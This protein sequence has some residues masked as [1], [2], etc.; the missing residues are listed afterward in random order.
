MRRRRD[1]GC[2]LRRGAAR[3]AIGTGCATG[4]ERRN[5]WRAQCGLETRERFQRGRSGAAQELALQA[6]KSDS[7]HLLYEQLRLKARLFESLAS[8][9]R[10]IN[11]TLNMDEAL[12]A[13][14]REACVLMGARMCSLM[15]LDESREWLDLHASHG[16]GEAYLKKP[17]LSVGDS[18]LGVVVRR[19]K[20]MQVGNVQTS[21]RYQN[22][23]LRG[24][25][26]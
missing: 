9:S 25:K 11:S 3:R 23:E 6:A 8:V 16:A 12:R 1:T 10:T 14:T 13:I 20:P 2:A 5:A 24:V 21:G 15:M 26:G 4:S 22:V 18:F 19:K 17:R 7:Q